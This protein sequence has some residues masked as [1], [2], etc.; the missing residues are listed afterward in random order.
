[1]TLVLADSHRSPRMAAGALER[2]KAIGRGSDESQSAHQVNSVRKAT[3]L[4]TSLH[5]SASLK[6]AR[7]PKSISGIPDKKLRAHL[8]REV[9]SQRRARDHAAQADQF[10]DQGAPGEDAGLIETERN[11]ERTARLTQREI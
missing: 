8:S 9:L 5:Q 4:P 3:R 7:P 10:L 1:M 11:L 6:G 2:Q